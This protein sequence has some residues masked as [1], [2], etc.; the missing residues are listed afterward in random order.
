M[1]IKAII[2]ILGVLILSSCTATFSPNDSKLRSSV[3]DYQKAE[4]AWLEIEDG[5]IYK[6]KT[7]IQQVGKTVIRSAGSKKFFKVNSGIQ[8]LSVLYSAPEGG[9]LGSLNLK[10]RVNIEAGKR[11]CAYGK[12]D[13][14]NVE[15]WIVEAISKKAVSVIKTGRLSWRYF[16]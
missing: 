10:F 8:N 15:I 14:D 13:G 7:M 5:G 11:Y 9:R 6:D 2:T 4:I 12:R 16:G 3:K 1:D